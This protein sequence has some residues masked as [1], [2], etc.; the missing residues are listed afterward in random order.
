MTLL[1]SRAKLINEVYLL[2]FTSYRVNEIK[3]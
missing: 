2:R 3:T 1:I